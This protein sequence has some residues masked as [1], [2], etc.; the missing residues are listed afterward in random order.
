MEDHSD[1]PAK[2]LQDQFLIASDFSKELTANFIWFFSFN[3]QGYISAMVIV[4]ADMY[5]QKKWNLFS[6]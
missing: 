6:Y 1:S 2:I 5:C 4:I 3:T